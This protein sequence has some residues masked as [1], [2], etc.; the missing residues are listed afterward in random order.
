MRRLLAAGA[1][2]LL[3]AFIVFA[4]PGS[5]C[6]CSCAEQTDAEAFDGADAVFTGTLTRS[7]ESGFPP[8]SSSDPTTL[9][10][11][12]DEVYKG[13]VA[14]VQGLLTP[15]SEA[16]CGWLPPVGEEYL[17]FAY[18][19][20]G[21]LN[22]GFCGGSRMLDG[23]SPAFGVEAAAPV[24]GEADLAETELWPYG[25]AAALLVAATGAGWWFLR[26]RHLKRVR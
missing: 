4:N 1:A 24:P 6:A 26:R 16:S 13:E 2:I 20:D 12:V 8:G 14:E 25:V 19:E 7:D 18:L 3:S 9:E 5:A 22:A 10:F 17:V 11:E 21:K 15:G 23:Q